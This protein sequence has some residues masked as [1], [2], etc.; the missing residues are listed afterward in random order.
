MQLILAS[1]SPYRR[2]LLERLGVPFATE[3]P[4]VDEDEVKRRAESPLAAVTELARR[5]AR[6]VA[7]RFPDAVVVGGD[8]TAAVD[9]ELLDKPGSEAAAKA[10]LR[11][12]AGRT[13]ELLTAVAIAR[14][15][16]L[17]EFVDLTTLHMRELDDAEIAR[18]VSAERPLDCAGSYKVEGLGVALFDRIDGSDHTAIQGLPLL[19]LCQELRRLGFALP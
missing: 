18:Y 5:K 8:Q 11:R 17:R 4:G 13:H 9:G 7:E 10:Q 1:T 19:R 3:A 16:E 15:D 6:A 12:L 14:G 2:A